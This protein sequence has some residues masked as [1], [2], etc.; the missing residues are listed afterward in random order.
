MA[1]AKDV[2][3]LERSTSVALKDVRDPGLQA[4]L[5]SFDKDGSGTVDLVELRAAAEA[6]RRTQAQGQLLKKVVLVLAVLIL[7]MVGINAGLTFAV[8]E[9]TRET[10]VSEGNL[11]EKGTDMPV[12]TAAARQ[13][14]GVFG[15]L[16]LAHEELTSLEELTL[17]MGEVRE[18]GGEEVD[19]RGQTDV[20][21]ARGTW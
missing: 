13:E 20:G 7:A 10:E 15:L 8:I 6:M 11:L 17:P 4:T 12:A 5:M 2:R 14:V 19:R 1:S 9:A 18:G 16:S 21:A 3:V